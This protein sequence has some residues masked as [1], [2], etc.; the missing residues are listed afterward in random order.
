VKIGEML[1]DIRRNDE[2]ANEVIRHLR[3]L[4]K[5][6]PL[7]LKDIDLNDIIQERP[8]RGGFEQSY[9]S[10][11]TSYQGRSYSTSASHLELGR[12]RDVGHPE[13]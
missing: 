4:V 13:R 7:E 11:V 8:L 12:E 5:K 6:V 10:V 2:R 1:G 3:S 9:H